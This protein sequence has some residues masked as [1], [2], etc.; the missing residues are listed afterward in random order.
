[1]DKCEEIILEESINKKELFDT[2]NNKKIKY[3]LAIIASI[4]IIAAVIT[5]SIGHFK[6]KVIEEENKPLIRNLGFD[7]TADKTYN[8]G[9]LRLMGK[10]CP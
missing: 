7:I 1:M 5:L 10:L 4:L 8:L 2:K 6:V 9:F 3:S